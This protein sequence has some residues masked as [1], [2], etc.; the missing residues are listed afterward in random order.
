MGLDLRHRRFRQGLYIEAHGFPSIEL[1]YH[2][3]AIHGDSPLLEKLILEE[4]AVLQGSHLILTPSR[5]GFRH[6]LMR[7]VPIERIDGCNG[8]CTET[9]ACVDDA[10]GHQLYYKDYDPAGLIGFSANLRF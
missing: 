6:L 9:Q 2:Y 7:G 10:G 1:P 8:T 4:R 3:P 5:T